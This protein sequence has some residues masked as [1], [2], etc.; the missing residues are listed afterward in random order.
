MINQDR[1]HLLTSTLASFAFSLLFC[2]NFLKSY[3]VYRSTKIIPIKFGTHV[4][5]GRSLIAQPG[6]YMTELGD[7]DVG[8]SLDCSLRTCCCAGLGICRQK[9]SGSDGSIAFLNAGGTIVYKNLKDGEI[10][11]V[12]SGSVVGF[13]DSVRLGIRF[14]G[15]IGTCCCGGEGCFSTT[16]KGPGRVYLQSMSFK[17]FKAAVTQTITEEERGGTNPALQLG[18]E[19]L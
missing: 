13:E 1:A 7:V 10:I 16:L 17:R 2:F 5:S 12:D 15:K 9:L 8:C 14:N 19:A 18:Q 4:G 6:V 3:Y 11:T